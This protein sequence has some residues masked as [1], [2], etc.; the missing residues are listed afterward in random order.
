MFNIF[1]NIIVCK[2]SVKAKINNYSILNLKYIFCNLSK[3]DYVTKI[4]GY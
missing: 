2:I 1:L 4:Y 3:G